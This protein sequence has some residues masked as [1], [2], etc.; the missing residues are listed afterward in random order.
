MQ[1]NRKDMESGNISE[2]SGFY[3]TYR[4]KKAF[5]ASQGKGIAGFENT[6]CKSPGKA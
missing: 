3:P 1:R 4:F 6:A 5:Y 2:V